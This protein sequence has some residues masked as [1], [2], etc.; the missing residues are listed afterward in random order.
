M[1]GLGAVFISL[2][3][4]LSL[5]LSLSVHMYIFMY[6]FEELPKYFL[7]DVSSGLHGSGSDRGSHKDSDRDDER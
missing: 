5:F 2:S 1:Y 6:G 4:S 7:R 3:L